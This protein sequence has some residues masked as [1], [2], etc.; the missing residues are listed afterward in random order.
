MKITRLTAT[1]SALLACFIAAPLRAQTV[2][3]TKPT[4][5]PASDLYPNWL[6]LGVESPKGRFFGFRP[7]A[8]DSFVR[9]DRVKKHWASVPGV[10]LGAQVRW[11]P[12]GRFLAYVRDP[13]QATRRTVLIQPMDTATGLPTGTARRINASPASWPAWSPD[14]RRIAY[15]IQDSGRFRI[16]IVPFNGGD[17]TFIYDAPGTGGDLAWSPDG[18]YIFAGHGTLKAATAWLRVNVETRH[19]D[20]LP[21]GPLRVV[22]YSPDGKYIAHWS[23]RIL[24]ISSA[25]T[26]RPLQQLY[27]PTRMI[28]VGWSQTVPG[29]ITAAEHVVPAALERISLVDGSIHPLMPF[30]E[31]YFKGVPLHSPDGRLIAFVREVNDLPQLHVAN[32]DGSNLRAIGVRGEGGMYAWSPSGKQIAYIVT[33]SRAPGAAAAGIHV[34]DV[35]TGADRM[36]VRT[37]NGGDPGSAIAWRHDGQALRYIWRPHGVRGTDREIHEITLAGTDRLLSRGNPSWSGY[38]YFI[39]DT[40]LVF[41]RGDGMDGVDI[42]TGAVK[43]LFRGSIRP[44]DPPGV[45]PDGTWLVLAANRDLDMYPQMISL[46]TGEHRAIPYPLKGEITSVDFTPDGKSLLLSSCLTC[47]DPNYKEKWDVVVMPLNGD[48]PRI[49]TSSQASFADYGTPVVSPDGKWVTVEAERSYNTRVVTLT[50]SRP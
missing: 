30:S 50:F 42:R 24:E 15:S 33:A 41:R 7:F 14:S 46:T 44:I 25:T 12:D 48:V 3:V 6:N 34:A 4:V 36:L 40:L 10:D 29:A 8:G 47:V 32:S 16:A 27:L 1:A 19:A 21:L 37:N 17:E 22:G 35:A 49:L 11:S 13:N 43:S 23:D 18:K 9:Y 20:T 31:P 26:G 39:N 28:P 5:T 38:P 45:S 2:P